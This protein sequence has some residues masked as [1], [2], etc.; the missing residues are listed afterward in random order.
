M[1]RRNFLQQSCSI[2][3]TTLMSSWLIEACSVSNKLV[4]TQL[5]GQE[6]ELN[7]NLL[8]D[9]HFQIVEAST[10][11]YRIAVKQEQ[12]GQYLA[13]LL[14]CTHARNPVTLTGN[15]FYCP[16]HGSRFD[17]QGNVVQGPAQKP[18]IH[19]P[20]NVDEQGKLHIQ[21]LPWMIES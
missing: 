4:Q 7:A 18:L 14:M 12:N 16:L 1:N 5:H 10:L 6:V 3:I 2:C 20:V 15:S 11:R 13:L 9:G 17:D 21:L 19:L 8:Q